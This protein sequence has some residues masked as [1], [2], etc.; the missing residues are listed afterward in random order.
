MK[1]FTLLTSMA[2]LAF[3]YQVQGQNWQKTRSASGFNG[4]QVSHGIDLY[5]TQSSAESLRLEAKGVEED[6]VVSEV[7]EGVLVLRIN[8]ESGIGSWG[9]NRSVKAYVSFKTLEKLRAGGGSDVYTQG[10]LNVGDLSVDLGGGSDARMDLKANHFSISAGG[11]S[12]AD[13]SGSAHVFD[14]S[15]SGG[16]DIKA[17]DFKADVVRV[18]ASGGSDAH[19]YATK[20]ISAEASGGSDIYYAGGAK[21]VSVRK[22][23]GSDVTRRD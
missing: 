1:R 18:K 20:E 22:S 9:K 21:T 5:L 11:G 15:A 8:R 4:I 7:K 2:A 16:S 17:T 13:L 23:G 19:V 12:D 14:V 6:E 3:S 10:T